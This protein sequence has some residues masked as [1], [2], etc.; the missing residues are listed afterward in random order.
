MRKQKFTL[1]YVYTK[2]DA[3]FVNILFSFKAGKSADKSTP[4]KKKKSHTS[5]MWFQNLMLI[6]EASKY[7]FPK[8]G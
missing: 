1:S 6:A 5:L 7:V 2:K 4:T 3:R 8:K